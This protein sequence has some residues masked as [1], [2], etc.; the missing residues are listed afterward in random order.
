MIDELDFTFLEIIE[1]GF[2]ES[3]MIEILL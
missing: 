1:N 2:V 3:D